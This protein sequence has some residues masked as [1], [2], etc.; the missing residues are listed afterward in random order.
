MDVDSVY[1]FYTL[2]IELLTIALLQRPPHSLSRLLLGQGNFSVMTDLYSP[3]RLVV[4][5][6]IFFIRVQWDEVRI[7]HSSLGWVEPAKGEW[8]GSLEKSVVVW[9]KKRLILWPPG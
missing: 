8:E 5:K 7:S 9:V 3:R 6:V 2:K 4:C 1:E